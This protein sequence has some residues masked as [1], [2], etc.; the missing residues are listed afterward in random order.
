[1]RNL[2]K[3]MK[4]L[5][6]CLFLL[7]SLVSFN[8]P[9]ADS[10]LLSWDDAT[11]QAS[12]S[13]KPILLFFSGSDWNAPSV[14]IKKL[15]FDTAE[16]KQFANKNLL[17]LH[18][19]LPRKSENQLSDSQQEENKKLAQRFNPYNLYPKLL[20]LS[21]EGKVLADIPAYTDTDKFLNEVRKSLK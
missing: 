7:I 5:T 20:L 1:M 3:L 13:N 19:D 15:V 16:F 9:N 14:K 11:T 17:L 21:A 6:L 8:S 4:H 12:Q 2:I 18:A 10:W